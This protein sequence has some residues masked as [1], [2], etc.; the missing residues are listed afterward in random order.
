MNILTI[1]DIAPNYT[2]PDQNGA[3]HTLSNYKGKWILIYFYPK[4][5]TP[6]CTTQACGIR[7]T[8][9][10]LQDVGLVTFG[11]S[12]DSVESHKKF[13]TK[14]YLPFTLLSDEEKNVLDEYGVWIEKSMFGKKYMGIQRSSF[15]IDTYGNIAKV[16]P[17]ASPKNHIDL[18]LKDLKELQQ[19]D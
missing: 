19:V 1:G 17:K 7:D 4:D 2:L 3:L 14:H 5:D 10:E 15:L 6:G 8:W 11:I 12:K 13:A 18:I 16:Y 9:S